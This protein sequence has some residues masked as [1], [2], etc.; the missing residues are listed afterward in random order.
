MTFALG[1]VFGEGVVDF[2]KNV[3]ESVKNLFSPGHAV[4]GARLPLLRPDRRARHRPSCATRFA[5]VRGMT[6]PAPRPRD[7][8]EGEGLRL[9]REQPGEVARPRG[10]R[11]RHR[12]GAEEGERPAAPGPRCSATALTALAAEHPELVAITAAMPSG[13]GT[14]IFQKTHPGALLR[15]RASPRGTRSPSPAGSRRRASGRSCAIYSTFLQRAYDNIIH[16]VAVQQLPVIFCMDRAG[17]VG[18]DGADPHG[19]VR[20]RLHA[21]GAGHDGDGAEGRRRAD[22]PAPHRAGAHGRARSAPAIRATRRPPTRVPPAEIPPV[23]YGTWEQLRVGQGRRDPRRRHD[24]AAGAAGGRAARRRRH[25]LRRRQLPLPQ[26][27]R[28][29]DA[30]RC[31]CASTASWSRSRRARS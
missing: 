7:H 25:R 2:A 16:D 30:R 17:L 27:A 4:R 10:L 14:N 28:P 23:P 20:H 31:C 6:R 18:E 12:R 21:G 11:S 8:P 15:R 24:G 9:R 29:R 26:A 13:T 1:G 22:R 5:F 3:E 19:A